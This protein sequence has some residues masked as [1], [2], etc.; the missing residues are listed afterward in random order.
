MSQMQHKEEWDAKRVGKI[1]ASHTHEIMAQGKGREMAKTRYA[2][3]VRIAVERITGVIQESYQ[4]KE[5][6]DGIELEDA[7]RDKYESVTGNIVEECLFIDYPDIPMVGASPDGLIGDDGLVELKVR[8]Q[9]NHATYLLA[10]DKIERPA[11]LQTQAQM[12]YT[13]RTWNDYVHYNPT[14]PDGLDIHINETKADPKMQEEIHTAVLQFSKEVCEMVE[15]LRE[16][17]QRNFQKIVAQWG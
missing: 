12:L 3:L 13:G 6:L 2:Y 5:M 7:A 4:S 8:K 14:Y 15:R 10:G 11:L 17:Q 16:I 9:Q 1:S